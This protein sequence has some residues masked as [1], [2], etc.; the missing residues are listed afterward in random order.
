LR[1]A[2][3]KEWGPLDNSKTDRGTNTESQRKR[4]GGEGRACTSKYKTEKMTP[5][6]EEAKQTNYNR[7]MP[8]HNWN[9]GMK[10]K[11]FTGFPAKDEL[12]GGAIMRRR[13][14][15]IRG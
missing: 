5:P 1:T 10:K 11:R 9:P 2:S 12:L 13:N 8:N 14:R 15:E 4:E 7:G 6:F 3:I